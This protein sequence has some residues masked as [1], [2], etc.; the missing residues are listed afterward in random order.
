MIVPDRETACFVLIKVVNNNNK[1]KCTYLSIVCHTCVQVKAL[2]GTNR[3]KARFVKQA[4]EIK[5][6]IVYHGFHLKTSPLIFCI[7]NEVCEG[8]LAGLDVHCTVKRHWWFYGYLRP[9]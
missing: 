4:E 8:R 7:L 2:K 1:T 6:K 5:I 9:L 3:L